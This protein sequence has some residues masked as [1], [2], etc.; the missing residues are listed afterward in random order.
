[1]AK[2]QKTENR[3]CKEIRVL[4]FYT[5]EYLDYNKKF[6]ENLEREQECLR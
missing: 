5:K 4:K 2:F 6:K 1:M 3:E